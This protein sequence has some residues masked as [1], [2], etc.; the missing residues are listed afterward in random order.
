MDGDTQLIENWLKESGTKSATKRVIP[1]EDVIEVIYSLI[2]DWKCNKEVRNPISAHTSSYTDEIISSGD[3]E[4]M[5]PD[6]RI[7]SS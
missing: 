2:D 1:S 6:I 7:L 5:P 4:T 3:S